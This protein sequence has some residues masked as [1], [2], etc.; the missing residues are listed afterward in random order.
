MTPLGLVVV[1]VAVAVLASRR[2]YPQLLAAAAGL[3]IGVVATVAG[4][5]VKTFFVIGAGA[6]A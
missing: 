3:P 1:L 5:S 6:C 2:G 4:Q